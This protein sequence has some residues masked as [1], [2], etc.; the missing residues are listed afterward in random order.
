MLHEICVPLISFSVLGLVGS[1]PADA[2]RALGPAAAAPYLSWAPVV[3]VLALGFYASMGSRVFLFMLVP[4]LLLQLPVGLLY[5]QGGTS[6]LLGVSAAV[7]VGGWIGQFIG[8]GIE[9]RK[10]SF[11]KDL[12]FLLVGPAWVM[13]LAVRTLGLRGLADPSGVAAAQT[14]Q[15][16]PGA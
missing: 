1:I 7:F 9:G 8:H 3:T 16:P 14:A 2:L 10:P 12:Q 11:F 13:D 15:V 5:A 4:A 6:L